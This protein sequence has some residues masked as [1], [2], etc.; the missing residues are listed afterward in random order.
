MCSSRQNRFEGDPLLEK[1][2]Q[3]TRADVS[4]KPAR[5]RIYILVNTKSDLAAIYLA[6]VKNKN[7][8][9]VDIVVEETPMLCSS[10]E[11]VQEAEKQRGYGFRNGDSCWVVLDRRGVDDD[12][13]RDSLDL[14]KEKNIE[15]VFGDGCFDLW[16][17]LHLRQITEQ[18]DASN[19]ASIQLM[20]KR[21][22]D[23]LGR[24]Y[25]FK[26]LLAAYT[27]GSRIKDAK[28]RS[29]CLFDKF[30]GNLDSTSPPFTN[31]HQ[32][33]DVIRD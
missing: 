22:M 33:L 18:D 13:F 31:V 1:I 10:L 7:N 11:A 4:L 21:E 6:K 8:L 25:S 30:E 24:S 9:E 23:K 14:A 20:I 19:F 29:R 15:V 2:T 27:Q 3:L 28:N 32:L 17:L 16:F 5:K 26:T 12:R